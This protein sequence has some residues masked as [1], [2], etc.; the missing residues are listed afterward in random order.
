MDDELEQP[1]KDHADDPIVGVSV[2]PLAASA[3]CHSLRTPRPETPPQSGM[4]RYG[5]RSSIPVDSAFQ[6]HVGEMKV[7]SL[8]MNPISLPLTPHP[9]LLPEVPDREHR[10]VFDAALAERRGGPLKP[11][12]ER[13]HLHHLAAHFR[14]A[15]MALTDDPPVVMTSS[16]TSTRAPLPT[17]PPSTSSA[18]RGPWSCP[19]PKNLPSPCRSCG[20]AS[21]PPRSAAPP[22]L[23]GR[24]W[25]RSPGPSSARKAPG[26]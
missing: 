21:R 1:T 4:C 26:R 10:P 8:G 23:P 3:E 9:A 19:E 5:R 7:R 18:C 15:S 25:R 16:S 11:V 22:P 17:P 20:N 13:Q 24:R 12:H 14:T 2:I 6:H